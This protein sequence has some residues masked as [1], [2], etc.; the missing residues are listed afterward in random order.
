MNCS[1]LGSETNAQY[2]LA[3]SCICP[4]TGQDLSVDSTVSS[5]SMSSNQFF[6]FLFGKG[7]LKVNQINNTVTGRHLNC[8]CVVQNSFMTVWAALQ[9]I[10]TCTVL[11]KAQVRHTTK[12]TPTAI[13]DHSDECW[14]D[15]KHC[16]VMVKSIT[17]VELLLWAGLSLLGDIFTF[18]M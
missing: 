4:N 15:G 9:A 13:W 6:T 5:A 10:I 14:M 2:K 8:C 17:I 11:P 7:G 18:V 12:E 16:S 3:R 1:N